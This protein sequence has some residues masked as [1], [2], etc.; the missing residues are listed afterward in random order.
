MIGGRP[1]LAG[2]SRQTN[3]LREVKSD[4]PLGATDL[5]AMKLALVCLFDHGTVYRAMLGHRFSRIAKLEQIK[6]R[7]LAI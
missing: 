1:R 3:A 5:R 2:D 6:L 7:L 4:I